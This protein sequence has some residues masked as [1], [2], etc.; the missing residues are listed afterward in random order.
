MMDADNFTP[1]DPEFY[2]VNSKTWIYVG[3]T[4][5]GQFMYHKVA[6]GFP[7]FVFQCTNTFAAAPNYKQFCEMRDGKPWDEI[8]KP[9]LEMVAR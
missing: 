5:P 8:L 6:D 2:Q 7:V 1:T 3:E 9:H 4:M